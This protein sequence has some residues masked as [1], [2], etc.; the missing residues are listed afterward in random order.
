MRAAFIEFP[1]EGGQVVK[2]RKSPVF[3]SPEVGISV[4]V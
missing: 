4:T 1:G 3:R 2:K